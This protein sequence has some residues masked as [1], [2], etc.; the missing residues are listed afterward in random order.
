MTDPHA[1]IKRCTR[2]GAVWLLW[3]TV[4]APCYAG[5]VKTFVDEKV[6]F[7][8]YKTYQW[9]PTKILAKSGIVEND[10]ILSPVIKGAVNRELA[11]R[12]LKEV[13]EEG[14]LQV[15]TLALDSYIPQLEAYIFPVGTYY[16]YPTPL[17]A[18]G[19]YNREGTLAVNLIDSRTK[20]SAFVG[21]VTESIDNKSGAGA[22]KIPMAAEKIFKKYPVKK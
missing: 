6:N 4:L 22:K 14:D 8:N 9:L 17:A 7:A 10:P 11:A 21:M 5:K 20:K 15:A 1:M 19:R 3:A 2:A 18:M 13:A 16:D 12:G